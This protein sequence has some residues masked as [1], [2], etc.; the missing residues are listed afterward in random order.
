[1]YPNQILP[2][3]LEMTETK[4]IK[5]AVK[6][7]LEKF[8][9]IDVLVNNAGRGM[10]S[11]IEEGNDQEVLD[12]FELNF[13][14][15][16]KLIKEVLPIMREKRSGTIINISSLGAVNVNPGSG[17]YSASKGALENM[18]LALSKEVSPLG[19]KVIL[20]EPGPFRTEFRV[21]SLS[22]AHLSISD[23]DH[24]SGAVMKRYKENP[25]NQSGDPDK[26]GKAIVEIVENEKDPKIILLGKGMIEQEEKVLLDR[27][28]EIKNWRQYTDHV[29]FDE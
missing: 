28:E 8:G 5:N 7:T 21:A 13:F 17:Y 11:A 3:A 4:S 25:Y 1:M 26:A 12:L 27:I 20:V 10:R 18:T 15:P 6:Q 19:I 23:Y 24:T 16:V 9:T 2:V 29:D 14:G 22:S